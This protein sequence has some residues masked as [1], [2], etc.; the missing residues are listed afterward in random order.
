MKTLALTLGCVLLCAC[1]LA[2]G[3]PDDPDPDPIDVVLIPPPSA[4]PRVPVAL[5]RCFADGGR[6]ALAAAVDNDDVTDHG[7]LLT[8]A[9]DPEG[10]VAVAA[11]DGTIKLWTMHGFLGTLSPGLL[12]YGAE[13][14]ATETTDMLFLGERVVAADTRGLVSAWSLDGGFDVLGG[15]DE[16]ITAVAMD[17][18][19][20]WL[21][22]A[23][24]GGRVI[25][26]SMGDV[27]VHGPLATELVRVRDLAYRADGSLLIA[28][29][30]AGPALELRDAADPAHVRGRFGVEGDGELVE[31]ATDGDRVAIAGDT[32]LGVLDQTLEPSWMIDAA[33]HAP[34][35]VAMSPGGALVFSAGA[36]GSLRAHDA[37][38]GAALD[39]IDVVD[40]VVVRVDPRGRAVLVG[41]RDGAVRAFECRAP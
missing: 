15:S 18:T 33:D 41:S 32:L 38:D 34:I 29:R 21:A 11:A 30:A 12:L 27:V 19:Q 22:H 39:Q 40:P 3:T 23:D 36:D 25:V 28:G 37:G 14:A 5:E 4:P 2:H 26:R 1:S 35:G 7:D 20:R 9:V 16:G 10:R 8:M 13:L 31:L 6:L 17:P 24:V